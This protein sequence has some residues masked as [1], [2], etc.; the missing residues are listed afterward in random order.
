MQKIGIIGSGKVAKVLANGFKKH[1][2]TVMMGTRDASK[3]ADWT[4]EGGLVGDM[5]AAAQFGELV[6]LAVSGDAAVAALDLIGI[7]HLAGKTV[8]DVSN[9]IAKQPPVNGVLVY[10]TG[11]NESLLERLQT[12]APEAHFVKAFS[13]VGSGLMVNPY[14][15]GG[16]PTMFICGNS[17]ASKEEVAT[18]LDQFGWETADMGKVE[19][20]RAI[21]P[22]AQLWCIPGMLNNQWM[23]AFKLLK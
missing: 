16:K 21:E 1:G 20:A 8:I 2:Y 15:E 17:A 5:S 7:D 3:L 6:V 14:F 13:C 12:A 23:H 9:P 22:L 11:P 19:G 10:F 4:A 18:I